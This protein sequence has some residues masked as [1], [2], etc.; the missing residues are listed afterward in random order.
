M[1]E[2]GATGGYTGKVTREIMAEYFGMNSSNINEDITAVPYVE[3][4]N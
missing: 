1:I 3:M 2:D 4:S